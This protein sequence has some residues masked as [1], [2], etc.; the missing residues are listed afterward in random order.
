MSRQSF[1][2]RKTDYGTI[3]LHW[4]VAAALTMAVAS[5]VGIAAETPDR[6]WINLLDAL[7]PVTT[8]WTTHIQSAV[9][10]VAVTIAYAIY[11]ARAGLAPRIRLDRVR[12]LGLFGRS[13]ARWGAFNIVLYWLFYLTMVSQLVTGGLLYFGVAGRALLEFHWIGTWAILL[14]PVLHVLT[15]WKLGGV[16]QLLR[17]VRPA[18]IMSPPP[19]LELAELLTLFAESSG[20]PLAPREGSNTGRDSVDE[21]RPS[22]C[23]PEG[24]GHDPGPIIR[25]TRA[26]P[27][28]RATADGQRS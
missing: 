7:L 11:V 28:H 5:G 20:H 3:I 27:K 26:L 14:F 1:R 15:H 23:Q 9:A 8:V 17:I 22:S 19:P 13:Q 21:D 10:L 18:R 4:L 24:P 2:H 12:L 16:A 6:T 25:R